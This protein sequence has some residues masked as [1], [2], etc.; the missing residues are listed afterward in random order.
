MQK[1][2]R[3]SM[4]VL[5]MSALA[6]G[7]NLAQAQNVLSATAN[8]SNLSFKLVDL[9]AND[10]ITPW[11]AFGEGQASDRTQ[12]LDR[13]TQNGLQSIQAFS[14][15]SMA[16]LSNEANAAAGTR[17]V[18]PS[19]DIFGAQTARFSDGSGLTTFEKGDRQLGT[20]MAMTAS[21]FT[22]T[23]LVDPQTGQL[24]TLAIASMGVSPDS[25]SVG[26]LLSPKTSLVIEG[27][28]FASAAIDE[29]T[30]RE[31]LQSYLVNTGPVLFPSLGDPRQHQVE[32][33]LGVSASL[34]V[35]GLN[36]VNSGYLPYDNNAAGSA[37]V[38]LDAWL[39]PDRTLV[40]G[41]DGMQAVKS[42]HQTVTFINTSPW[43]S[44]AS[45]NFQT[46][47]DLKIMSTK[48][49]VAVPEP[50]TYALMGLGLVGLALV[51][52]RRHAPN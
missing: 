5:V 50:G 34:S 42:S 1:F 17:I 40:Y 31:L 14:S 49:A 46:I 41:T 20:Q 15:Y 44:E 26:F 4:A 12:K 16:G 30:V 48:A 23:A 39:L 3:T 8:L 28:F 10:G 51:T 9:D 2:A 32:I 21:Q 37:T 22:S 19:A 47:T 33:R 52:R 38:E 13:S 25:S 6:L 35:S 24:K 7:S 18:N 29:A 43:E 11:V 36:H 27:D 45:M